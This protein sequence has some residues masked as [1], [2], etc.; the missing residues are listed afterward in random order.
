[1]VQQEQ[2]IISAETYDWVWLVRTVKNE[3]GEQVPMEVGDLLYICIHDKRTV[4][5]RQRS[6]KKPEN[7]RLWDGA[8][9]TYCAETGTVSGTLTDKTTFEMSITPGKACNVIR[10]KHKRNPDQGQWGGDDGWDPE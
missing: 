10:S 6:K 2:S 5:F 7:E 1:M 8:T 4:Q 9:G 3:D